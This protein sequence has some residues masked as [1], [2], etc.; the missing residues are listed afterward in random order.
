MVAGAWASAPPEKVFRRSHKCDFLQ[1]IRATPYLLH[2]PV[3]AFLFDFV[4]V[5]Q[6]KNPGFLSSPE[7]GELACH[8]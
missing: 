8:N 7:H 4:L 3:G 6:N 5:F 2:A 1:K